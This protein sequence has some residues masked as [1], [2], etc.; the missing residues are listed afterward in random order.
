M[1]LEK[2][3]LSKTPM[4]QPQ[5]RLGGGDCYG[6][7]SAAWRPIFWLARSA[8]STYVWRP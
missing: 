2:P 1:S 7:F 6:D 8:G 3:S 5:H 4:A